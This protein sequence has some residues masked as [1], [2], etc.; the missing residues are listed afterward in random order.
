MEPIQITLI[1]IGDG[2]ATIYIAKGM[3]VAQAYAAG[4]YNIDWNKTTAQNR[5][6]GVN[7]SHTTPITEDNM[8]IAVSK[9]TTG[10]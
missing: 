1:T 2:Q 10:N 8:T 4:G 6:N 5:A 9:V 7:M 3:T